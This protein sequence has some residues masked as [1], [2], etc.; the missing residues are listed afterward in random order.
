MKT[1]LKNRIPLMSALGIKVSQECSFSDQ[2]LSFL[3]GKCSDYCRTFQTQTHYLLG[4]WEL[5]EVNKVG[6]SPVG[7]KRLMP[8]TEGMLK[9]VAPR[10]VQKSVM[11]YRRE[12]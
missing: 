9:S 11:G 3:W 5:I 7:K 1:F 4:L 8:S 2:K 6:S 12:K 10:R